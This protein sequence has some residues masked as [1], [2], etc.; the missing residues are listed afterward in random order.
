[1]H[2]SG[3]TIGSWRCYSRHPVSLPWV[4]GV[5]TMTMALLPMVSVLL[6]WLWI[7]ATDGGW[8]LLP[9]ASSFATMVVQPMSLAVPA[10]ASV[11]SGRCY[12]CPN[13]NTRRCYCS[14]QPLLP[15]VQADIAVCSGWCNYQR[16]REAYATAIGA[17]CSNVLLVGAY[18]A[19]CFSPAVS[20]ATWYS[21]ALA[22]APTCSSPCTRQSSTPLQHLVR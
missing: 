16:T 7:I 3:A 20:A 19:T 5:A 15:V 14:W 4:S 6:L 22:S 10:D 17:L 13:Q 9:T 1:M 8:V 2:V 12:Q 18:A 11:F 21:P